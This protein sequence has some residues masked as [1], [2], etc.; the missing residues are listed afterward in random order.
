[1]SAVR[2][3]SQQPA[4]HNDPSSTLIGLI[5]QQAVLWSICLFFGV[6]TF[7]GSSVLALGNIWCAFRFVLRFPCSDAHV[8]AS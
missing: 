3:H 5:G 7:I 8:S 1:V 6:V 2:R 4:I